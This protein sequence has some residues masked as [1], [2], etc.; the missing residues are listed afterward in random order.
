MTANGS[1]SVNWDI[2]AGHTGTAGPGTCTFYIGNDDT[3]TTG[4]T[5][6][7]PAY[8]CNPT[9]E[10][11]ETFN[12]AIT[13]VVS[14]MYYLQFNWAAGDGSLWWS[15]AAFGVLP[16]NLHIDDLDSTGGSVPATAVNL[17][18]PDY[19]SISIDVN[20]FLF[21][22]IQG[23]SKGFITVAAKVG[24][25]PTQTVY[26]KSIQ[27]LAGETGDVSFCASGNTNVT[28]YIAVFA[29]ASASGSYSFQA[30]TYNAFVDYAQAFPQ[31]ADTIST[32]SKFYYAIAYSTEEAPKSIVLQASSSFGISQSLNCISKPT[33]DVMVTGN[34]ACLALSSQQGPKYIEVV[35]TGSTPN[36]YKLGIEQGSCSS[37][38]SGSI[39]LTVSVLG[40]ALA[41]LF[42]VL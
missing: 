19:Y 42:L 20:S 38:N 40:L 17:N 23:P 14:E 39:Q 31:V 8:D 28:G 13:N 41:L 16:P 34:S 4:W 12:L 32:G 15:C 5:Q 6:V 25:L 1:L 24:F 35:N 9:G 26:D 30:S 22:Q 3:A 37:L 2:G 7:S 10:H 18:G 27:I 33:P 21:L 36:S 29:D 11:Y